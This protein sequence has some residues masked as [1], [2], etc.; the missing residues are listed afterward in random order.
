MKFTHEEENENSIVFLDMKLTRLNESLSLTWYTK[1]NGTGL[2]VK[3]YVIALPKYKKYVVSGLVHRI[4][5]SCNNWNNF[6]D[7]LTKAK[8]ILHNNQ[9]PLSFIEPIIKKQSISLMT[10]AEEENTAEDDE[11]KIEEILICA[12]QRKTF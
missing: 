12:I 1:T 4:F 6:D 11:E 7:S 10:K 8:M 5:R 3:F 2:A 9:Q